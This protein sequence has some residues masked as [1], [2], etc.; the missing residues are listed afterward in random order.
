MTCKNN[1]S[2]DESEASKGLAVFHFHAEVPTREQLM[3]NAA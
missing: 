1:N 3:T 2:T